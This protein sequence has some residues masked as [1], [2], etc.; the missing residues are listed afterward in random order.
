MDHARTYISFKV[1]RR[2]READVGSIVHTFDYLNSGRCS[3]GTRRYQKGTHDLYSPSDKVPGNRSD[4]DPEAVRVK[5][6]RGFGCSSSLTEAIP[7]QPMRPSAL[8]PF[9]VSADPSDKF[10]AIIQSSS[11][12]TQRQGRLT[13]AAEAEIRRPEHSAAGLEFWKPAEGLHAHGRHDVLPS[14]F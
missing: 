6:V 13:S 11:E 4:S 10:T 7:T 8:S 1:E 12:Y 14:A 5:D 2:T 3:N 9:Q